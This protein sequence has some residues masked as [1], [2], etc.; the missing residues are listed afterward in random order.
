MCHGERINPPK[1]VLGAPLA[2]S[3]VLEGRTRNRQSF[4]YL[5][6]SE[7]GDFG[8]GLA[9]SPGDYAVSTILAPGAQASGITR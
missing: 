5:D 6:R 2:E 7:K 3:L 1:R 9:I 4:G 8:D